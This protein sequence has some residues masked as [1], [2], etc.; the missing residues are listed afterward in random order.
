M[1]YAGADFKVRLT[2]WLTAE[3]VSLTIWRP[4]SSS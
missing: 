1:I 4:Q 2:K 3:F